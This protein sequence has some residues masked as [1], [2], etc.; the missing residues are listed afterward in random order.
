[1]ITLAII[2]L[3]ARENKEEAIYFAMNFLLCVYWFV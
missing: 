1:M 3:A 2:N